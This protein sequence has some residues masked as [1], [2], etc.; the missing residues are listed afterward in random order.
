MKCKSCDDREAD[1]NSEFCKRCQIKLELVE[2]KQY[3]NTMSVLKDWGY[4]NG[5][6]KSR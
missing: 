5:K 6:N 3:E 1:K 2:E 4:F